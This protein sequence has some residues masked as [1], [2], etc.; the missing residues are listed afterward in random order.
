MKERLSVST[1]YKGCSRFPSFSQLTAEQERY[2]RLSLAIQE[3]VS[4]I[5]HNEGREFEIIDAMTYDDDFFEFSYLRED[6]EK[7]DR[8]YLTRF[9]NWFFQKYQN[10]TFLLGEPLEMSFEEPI[11]FDNVKVST[12]YSQAPLLIRHGDELEAMFV[13]YSKHGFTKAGS[14]THTKLS[15]F[16]PFLMARLELEK[17][18]PNT[19]IHTSY[20]SIKRKN[21][22]IGSEFTTNKTANS[23]Y[24]YLSYNEL[25]CV[26]KQGVRDIISKAPAKSC[27][28]CKYEPLCTKNCGFVQ[29]QEATKSSS[30]KLPNYTEEQKKA[31]LQKEGA[32]LLD[33]GPGSGKTAT[34]V[35]RTV[36]MVNDGIMPEN[37][38]LIAFT[39][40]AVEEL[41]DRLSPLMPKGRMPHVFTFNAL[42]SGIIKNYPKEI[43]GSEHPTVLTDIEQ[44]ELIYNMLSVFPKM[45]DFSYEVID[46]NIGLVNL[47][48]SK[49]NSN[50]ISN[51]FSKD[52]LEF[53]DT[54]KNICAA[55]GYITFSEQISLT[56]SY[57]F[58]H[59]EVVKLYNN[60]YRY[61]MVD[62]AQDMDDKQYLLIKLLGKHQNL[63][64]AGD[65][66]QAIYSFRNGNPV[67]MKMFREEFNATYIP[68]TQ[69]FRSS[70]EIVQVAKAL[71]KPL[72]NSRLEK[73]MVSVQGQSNNLPQIL[74]KNGTGILD[75][76]KEVIQKGYSYGDI[77]VIGR[78]NK[79]LSDIKTELDSVP[80]YLA[81]HQLIEDALFNTLHCIL[82]FYYS[83][84]DNETLM[85]FF[86]VFDIELNDIVSVCPDVQLNSDLYSQ[87]LLK[88]DLPSVTNYSAYEMLQANDYFS[89]LFSFVSHTMMKIESGSMTVPQWVEYTS[90]ILDVNGVISYDTIIEMAKKCS[91]IEKFYHKL[92]FMYRFG[93]STLLENEETG[94]IALYTAH[95][96]KGKEFP[97][98]IVADFEKYC[99]K[100]DD[101]RLSY[102]SFTRAKELLYVMHDSDAR[103]QLLGLIKTFQ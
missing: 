70:D 9:V 82:K 73:N 67:Y 15:N 13:Y 83:G 47:I 102:V 91:S 36:Q 86:N 71:L 80:C 38:L 32:M 6:V 22:S 103:C 97:V 23:N 27:F 59:P 11:A 81:K 58:Q 33:A 49:I 78:T 18:F 89:T 57:L 26:S 63:C 94:K 34:L 4:S 42:C 56:V 54:Y 90:T 72:E 21:D 61:I 45:T 75:I 10:A 60:I 16:L 96:S 3:I 12:V 41:I 5:A 17:K 87:I 29:Q 46:G 84:F 62:E 53:V 88:L 8:Y 52:F 76:V 51:E 30:Y 40:K 20:V 28:S 74:D 93:D 69:N 24:Q 25:P 92:D 77:A 35:G 100:S 14:T 101:I 37:I 19:V 79:V 55:R 31:I 44:K 99:L 65:G 48:A 50:E 85:L 95:S 64:L 98:V 43:T 66:D 39:N 1:F 2:S 7:T 68:L